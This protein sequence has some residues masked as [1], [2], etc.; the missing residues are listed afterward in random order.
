MIYLATPYSKY[1]RGQDEAFIAAANIAGRLIARGLDVFSPIVHGHPL[2]E[3]GGLD[4]LDHQMWMRINQPYLEWC[5][6]L[7][8]ATMQGWQASAGV[9]A[10]IK[11][12]ADNGLPISNVD[13]AT[14]RITPVRNLSEVAS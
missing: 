12:F 2:S 5:D 8:V 10:E 9:E 13:P 7:Y 3:Y 14:L 6:E 4:R 11:Y 1:H